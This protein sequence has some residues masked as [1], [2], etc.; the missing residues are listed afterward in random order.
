MLAPHAVTL[1]ATKRGRDFLLHVGLETVRC[2]G[3][4]F[5]ALT[6]IGRRV[7]AGDVLLRF[8]LDRL[9]RTA[10]SLVSPIVVVGSRGFGVEVLAAGREGRFSASRS[11][12]CGRSAA[13]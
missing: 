11:S 13:A 7:T 9:A 12:S 6:A 2:G 1:R 4:G 10:A 5:E 3:V 8:D